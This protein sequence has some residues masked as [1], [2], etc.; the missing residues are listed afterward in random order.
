[1]CFN[2]RVPEE[3]DRK[4]VEEARD[5]SRGRGPA[6]MSTGGYVSGHSLLEDGFDD[7]DVHGV[8]S[9]SEE[10]ED[11]DDDDDDDE[12]DE[13]SEDED[14]DEHLIAAMPHERIASSRCTSGLPS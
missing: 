1:M 5:A 8:G 6:R 12:E 2:V 3:E 14:E 4:K 11:S 9:S 10:E 7:D 13:D